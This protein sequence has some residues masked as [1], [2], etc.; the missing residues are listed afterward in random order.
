[1]TT[2]SQ[3][4]GEGMEVVVVEPEE[5]SSSWVRPPI[6]EEELPR[7]FL[8]NVRGW[9]DVEYY[10]KGARR[11]FHC[12]IELVEDHKR[13][14]K[15]LTLR[16]AYRLWYFLSS[17]ILEVLGE[18][19][20]VLEERLQKAVTEFEKIKRLIE[21][22]RE[23]VTLSWIDK[24]VQRELREYHQAQQRLNKLS[25][26]R[27]LVEKAIDTISDAMNSMEELMR[28]SST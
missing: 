8:E 2:E 12:F 22:P 13:I 21:E 17:Y 16:E 23:V 6:D 15:E 9:V 27:E 7:L 26:M 11:I 20:V 24:E 14:V 5:S 3:V 28:A 25:R 19:E 4:R 1:M 18:E 10:N